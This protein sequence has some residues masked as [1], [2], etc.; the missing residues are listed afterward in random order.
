VHRAV[1][2]VVLAGCGPSSAQIK[3]ANDATYS[4]TPQEVFAIS[5]KV[6]AESYPI[7]ER[8]ADE[9]VFATA[10]IWFTDAGRQSRDPEDAQKQKGNL[11]LSLAVLVSADGAGAKVSVSATAVDYEPGK[12][13]PNKLDTADKLPKWINDRVDKLRVAIHERVQSATKQRSAK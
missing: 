4:A 7:G 11:Q 5:E 12:P 2:A 3:E 1:V 8:M 6:T 13:E 9:L 10:P